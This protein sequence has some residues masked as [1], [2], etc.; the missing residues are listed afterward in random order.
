M[1][2]EVVRRSLRVSTQVWLILK[3]FCFS[4]FL[5]VCDPAFV[6]FL[7]ELVL[8][9]QSLVVQ[10]SQLSWSWGASWQLVLCFK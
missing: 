10:S 4:G 7:T 6:C 8:E 9:T 1:V 5:C 2:T 3:G